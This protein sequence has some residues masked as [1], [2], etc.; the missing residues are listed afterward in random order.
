[1][2]IIARH[3]RGKSSRESDFGAIGSRIME[4]RAVSQ[5][6]AAGWRRKPELLALVCVLTFQLFSVAAQLLSGLLAH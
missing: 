5:R 1:V 3:L 4:I 2:L 6:A